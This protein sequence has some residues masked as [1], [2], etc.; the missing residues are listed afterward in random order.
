MA[1][2][3]TRRGLAR[4]LLTAFALLLAAM[5]AFSLVLV[6]H[7]VA[8][9]VRSD[10]RENLERDARMLAALLEQPGAEVQRFASALKAPGGMRVTI[11]APD[12]RVLG[13]S[14]IAPDRL[15]SLE[16]HSHRPEIVTALGGG[17]G[18]DVRRSTTLERELM[19]V[20]A[21]V[22]S[23]PRM[24]VRVAMPVDQIASTVW[25][26][27]SAVLTALAGGCVLAVV[28]GWFVSRRLSRPVEAMTRAAMEMTRG[29]FDVDIPRLQSRDELT[30]L[31]Q[32]L[33]HLRDELAR[34]IDDLERERDKLR[35]MT[36]G[37]SEGVALLEGDAIAAANPA[38]AKLL[39]TTPFVEGQPLLEATR[40]PE[41]GEIVRAA[42]TSGAEEL[43]DAVVG[44]RSLRLRA[45]AFDPGGAGRTVVMVSDLTEARRV[46]RL[47]RDFVAN[48]SHELR[49]PVAAIV[50]AA[51]TLAH[52]AA[53][54]PN[55]R[56]SFVGI[57]LRHAQRLSRLTTDLLDL[58]RIEAGYR[59]TLETMPL[60][61]TVQTM[62]ASLA[63]RAE[64][65]K[66]TLEAAVPPAL[67]VRAD[68][69]AVEQI[70]ANLVDNAIKY[71]PE[72]GRVRVTARAEASD[73]AVSVEDTGHGIAVEHLPRLFE[74]FYRVDDARSR[75]LGGTGLGL[76]IVKHLAVANGGEV[77]VT[78]ELGRGTRFTVTLPTA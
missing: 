26:A 70:L 18:F 19:Y 62:V 63:A 38:F 68:R 75:E 59:P 43:R 44:D 4:R 53:D 42:Q 35:S 47:R 36:Q 50:G 30:A 67:V 56:A 58:A 52:G 41:L 21:P 51:E 66:I 3:T 60:A 46:E 64:A 72:G 73:V 78:S 54:D 25:R 7:W 2:A 65:K 45:R 12:G 32:A 1:K 40:T 33:A 77:A 31:A 37:M 6:R 23:P 15:A 49:T 55:A 71:T 57:L 76:A 16:N 8:D 28:L 20:A 48:A 10:V 39:Q 22:G 14:E 27:Q 9:E 24:V 69:A 5:V 61:P 11:V 34:H 29:N 74:R 17:I 13:D